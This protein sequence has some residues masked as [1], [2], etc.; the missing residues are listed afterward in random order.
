[1]TDLDRTR[2]SLEQCYD[3]IEALCDR[4]DSAQ[5]QV[6]SLCPDWLA[7]DVVT[8]LGMMERVMT[9]W[10][11]GSVE[12]VPPLDR[13]EPYNE[14]VAAPRRPGLGRPDQRDLRRQRRATL[15][16]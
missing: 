1:M 4:M 8:H 16:R 12:E 9:G 13:V 7:R 6:Q 10:L 11:P 5:W 14:Q 3:A 15:P 2:G